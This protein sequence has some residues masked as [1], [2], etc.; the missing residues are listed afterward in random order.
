MKIVGLLVA[1]MVAIGSPAYAQVNSIGYIGCSNSRDSVI[2]Y[3]ATVGNKNY[4][5]PA[6]NIGGGSIEQWA[7]IWSPYWMAF[8]GMVASYGKP[9]AVWVQLCEKLPED[10]VTYAQVVAMLGNLKNKVPGA[11]AYISAINGY[12]PSTL[13]HLMG[14][15]TP[16]GLAQGNADT[17]AW[18]LQAVKDGLAQAGPIMGPL[19]PQLV[20]TDDCHP[21]DAGMALLGG[22]LKNFFDNDL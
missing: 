2:G 20:L 21:N 5:W 13:C 22:Q 17:N 12:S 8:Q 9:R 6:Y 14:N 18:A 10:P 3:H 15:L 4:L 19:T 7:D 16:A 1:F 11:V